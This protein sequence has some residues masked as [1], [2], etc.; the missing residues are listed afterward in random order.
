MASASPAGEDW[1]SGKLESAAE[2][3]KTE[4]RTFPACVATNRVGLAFIEWD[5]GT[6]RYHVKTSMDPDD[7]IS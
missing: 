4:I 5:E 2:R 3:E 6:N 7:A 1:I